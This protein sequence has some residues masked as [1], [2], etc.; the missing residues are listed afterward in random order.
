M[1]TVIRVLSLLICLA[2]ACRI[3]SDAGQQTMRAAQQDSIRESA[4]RY[5]FRNNASGQQQTAHA[6]CISIQEH[7]PPL[8]LLARFRDERIPVLPVS[9][10]SLRGLN[11]VLV[12][13]TGQEALAFDMTSEIYWSSNSEVYV[14]GSY[15]EAPL[16]AGGY[17]WRLIR[18]GNSWI[19][20]SARM[21]WIS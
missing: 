21:R 19:V 3:E 6:L 1:P 5:V 7:D 4:F 10:C 17:T 8:S 13:A 2:V 14:D 15:V 12:R 18:R 9:A 16:S 20:T 11:G